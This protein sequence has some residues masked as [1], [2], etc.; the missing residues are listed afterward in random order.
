MNKFYKQKI[1]WKVESYDLELN[2]IVQSYIDSKKCTARRAER[3]YKMKA[4]VKKLVSVFY[5]LE[6][7]Y[8]LDLENDIK[9]ACKRFS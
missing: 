2:Y 9:E 6:I 8:S 1:N 5:D 4:L 3:R 7:N